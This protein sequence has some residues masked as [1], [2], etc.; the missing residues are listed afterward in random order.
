VHRAV[1]CLQK[2]GEQAL[3][4]CA[5][6]EGVHLL[7]RALTL[8]HSLPDEDSRN[9]KELRIQSALGAALIVL[10]GF[11]S[12]EVEEAYG[13]AWEL[14][15]RLGS[16]PEIFQVMA[17]LWN[18]Y[19]VKTQ[20][21]RSHELAERLLR[22]AVSMNDPE[23]LLQANRALGET[24]YWL[25]D[26]TTARERLEQVVAFYDRS[27][28]SHQALSTGQDPG[29]VSQAFMA[30]TLWLLGYPDQA[31]ESM[32]RTLALAQELEHPHSVAMAL[33]NFSMIHQF[34]LEPIGVKERAEALM[35][36]SLDEGFQLWAAGGAIMLGWALSALGSL[37]EGIEGMQRGITDWRATGAELPV[38]YYLSLLAEAYG[39]SGRPG[40]GLELLEEALEA[41]NRSGEAWWRAE[42]YRL[43]GELSLLVS[44]KCEIVLE[45]FQS[46]LSLARQQR[47]KS[48]ELRAAISLCG[49]H[50]G[51]K[52]AEDARQILNTV[53]SSFTEGFETPDLKNARAILSG[54]SGRRFPGA[55]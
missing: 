41:S 32:N 25:G 13:R 10:K 15:R 5:N 52:R 37:E 7:R 2:A 55:D 18:F 33:Q 22:L 4:S 6:R 16:A 1:E 30:W 28:H 12:P 48:L 26:L 35:A 31:L 44:G 51:E 53:C 47:A 42:I 14:C 8:L 29:V 39:R 43:T 46:A 3:L 20:L 36:V 11:A 9:R 19:I 40:Q 24:S 27:Q 23:A 21:V 38:P 17:G 45:S 34:R 54:S 50:Q 49:L